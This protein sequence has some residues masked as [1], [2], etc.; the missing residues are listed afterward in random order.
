ML[1]TAHQTAPAPSQVMAPD[2]ANAAGL[3][4]GLP[5]FSGM[6]TEDIAALAQAHAVGNHAVANA[7]I[8]AQAKLDARLSGYAQRQETLIEHVKLYCE[9]VHTLINLHNQTAARMEYN[10]DQAHAASQT[11][12]RS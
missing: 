8:W 2:V 3:A 5:N 10:R 9:G 7:F 12:L 11:I 1:G 4:A 6:T